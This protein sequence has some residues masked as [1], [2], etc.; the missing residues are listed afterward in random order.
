M[1]KTVEIITRRLAA[2]NEREAVNPGRPILQNMVTEKY[3]SV[4]SKRIIRQYYD[5]TV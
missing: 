5:S 2:A 3:L 4:K 1:N